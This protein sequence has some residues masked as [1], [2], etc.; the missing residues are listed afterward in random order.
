MTKKRFW[1]RIGIHDWHRVPGSKVKCGECYLCSSYCEEPLWDEVCIAPGCRAANLA[2]T[3]YKPDVLA[4]K[5]FK[6][7]RDSL[8][9]LKMELIN[10]EQE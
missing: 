7:E 1:C 9:K 2:A 4:A 10:G 8:A 6:E 5:E 3:N